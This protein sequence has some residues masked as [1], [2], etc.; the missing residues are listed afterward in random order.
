MRGLEA[1]GT[2]R[3]VGSQTIAGSVLPLVTIPVSEKS[4]RQGLV[5]GVVWEGFRLRGLRL[6]PALFG[7][8]AGQVR[9]CLSPNE[10]AV[11]HKSGV[12][13]DHRMARP[14]SAII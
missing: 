2:P 11:I 10:Q 12:N 4:A 9:R 6:S 8:G 1:A 14:W 7:G 5:S 3:T 13:N